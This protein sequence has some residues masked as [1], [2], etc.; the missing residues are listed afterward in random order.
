MF[1]EDIE[2][3]WFKI[4]INSVKIMSSR[5]LREFKVDSGLHHS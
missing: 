4:G 5:P 3:D 2:M 1:S